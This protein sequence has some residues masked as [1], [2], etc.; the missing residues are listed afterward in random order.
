[1]A[2]S[3]SNWAHWLERLYDLRRDKRGSHERPHKPVLLLAILDLLDRGILLD[4]QVPFTKELVSTFR[5]F[6]AVVLARDDQPKI[7]NPFFFLSGNGF[8]QV[9]VAGQTE[10]LFREGFA[11]RAPSASQLR[12][13][14]AAGRFNAGLWSLIRPSPHSSTSSKSSRTDNAATPH[15]EVHHQLSSNPKEKL[16]SHPVFSIRRF[17]A[18]S[19]PMN[20]NTTTL[21]KHLEIM[22]EVWSGNTDRTARIVLFEK[23]FLLLLCIVLMLTPGL[24]VRHFGGL[25]G[26]VSRKVANEIYVFAKAVLAISVLYWGWWSP[27]WVAYIVGWLLADTFFNLAGYIFLRNFWQN[28]YSWNR[29]VLLILTNFVEYTSWFSCLYLSKGY[30]VFSGNVVTRS[31]DAIYFS[32]VTAA[33]VGYG[34]ITPTP[35]GRWLVTL[36]I[37]C[38][39]FYMATVVSYF[40]SNMTKAECDK[41]SGP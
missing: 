35:D 25:K 39:L 22:Q 8:W 5:R 9:L 21:E 1:V 33:T 26:R 40:V 23:A 6:F 18:T 4:N 32:V 11:G 10:P 28:P 7:Q 13:Q 15:S 30:L 34:D 17:K 12:K 38:S 3:E 31:I 19:P 27:S 24:W 16:T 14:S 36:E 37:A 20:S 2:V 41:P 29:S